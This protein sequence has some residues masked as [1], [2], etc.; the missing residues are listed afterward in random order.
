MSALLEIRNVGGAQLEQG[1]SVEVQSPVLKSSPFTDRI[2][3][4]GLRCEFI[5]PRPNLTIPCY[6]IYSPLNM[7][8]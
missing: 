8:G 5:W 3:I 1:L 7:C 2:A 6:F 4:L